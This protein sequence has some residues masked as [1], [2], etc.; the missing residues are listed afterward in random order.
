MKTLSAPALSRRTAAGALA[1]V[2]AVGMLA[3]SLAGCSS[4]KLAA[5][6]NGEKITAAQLDS[7]LAQLKIQSPSLFEAGSGMTEDSVR[8]AL[9]DELIN[10]EL[11][12][13]EAATRKIEVTDAEIDK[14]LETVRSGYT[15]EAAFTSALEA[16]GYTLESAREQIKWYLLSD[17]LLANEVPDKSVTDAEIKAYYEANPSNYT[18]EASKRASHI[19]F[20]ADDKATAEKVLA[21]VKGGGDFAAL[22]KKYSK[23]PGSA[24]NGGDLGWPTVAYVKEFEAAVADLKVGEISGLVKTEFGYHIITV[25]DERDAGLQP[26]ADVTADIRKTLL[27]QKRDA[28]YNSLLEKLRAAAKI[29]IIDEKVLAVKNATTDTGASTEATAAK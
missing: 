11:L 16:Q 14:E 15:D 27:S 10:R 9:L 28:A 13:Q 24:K 29:E 7:Q 20:D 18:V 25:T 5:K 2:L 6:V 19:L 23:D 26:L 4:A 3:L 8:A 12:T 17:K 21:E 1:A 22:A